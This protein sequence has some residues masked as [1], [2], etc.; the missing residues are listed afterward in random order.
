MRRGILP[1]KENRMSL[2]LG[3]GRETAEE[4]PGV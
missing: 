3:L 4:A 2:T 1:E